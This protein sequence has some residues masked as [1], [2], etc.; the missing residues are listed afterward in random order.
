MRVRGLETEFGLESR[1]RLGEIAEIPVREAKLVVGSW[2][3]GMHLEGLLEFLDYRG[4]PLVVEM[5]LGLF[6]MSIQSRSRGVGKERDSRPN[7][8]RDESKPRDLEFSQA[9]SA[10]R[11]HRPY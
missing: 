8:Q 7:G 11:R 6:Q 1:L 9:R 2:N 5:D 3:A 4:V 10:T